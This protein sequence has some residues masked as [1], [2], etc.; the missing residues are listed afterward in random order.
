M[1]ADLQDPP[2]VVLELAAKWREGY[3][4]VDARRLSQEGESRFK[5]WT[6]GLCY[7]LI[8]AL[9]AI[10]IPADVG[11]FRLVDRK[12]LDAFL[13]MPERDR[14]VGGMFSWM[15]FRQTAVPF[16]RLS[17]TL[18]Q[19]EYG[20]STILRLAFDGIV[21]FLDIPLRFAL[22]AG[23]SRSRHI[24]AFPFR[25]RRVPGVEKAIG[26]TTTPQARFGLHSHHPLII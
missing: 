4:I 15:V 20:W 6:A 11:D 5:R 18:D 25:R 9:T 3:E 13:A 12:A 16:H 24:L 1:D 23:T 17:R 2:E 10:D 14:F 21:G 7:R 8:R 22:W 19:T 26:Q